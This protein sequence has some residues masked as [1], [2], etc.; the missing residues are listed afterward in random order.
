MRALEI[1]VK[2]FCKSNYLI[3]GYGAPTKA[4]LLLSMA[5]LDLKE[6]KFILEDNLL[7][8]GRYMPK[9]G[10]PIVD[11]DFLKTNKPDVMIILAW[12]FSEDIIEKL[13]SFVNWHMKCI[14]PLPELEI[15]DI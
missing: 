13:K 15:I 14:I 3:A 7:K 1:K 8:V 6:I 9:T 10:I 11:K 4:S 2:E 5:N 12:N